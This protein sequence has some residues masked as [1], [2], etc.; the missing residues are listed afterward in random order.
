MT[1]LAEAAQHIAMSEKMPE[2]FSLLKSTQP[3]SRD[4]PGAQT[5]AALERTG[6]Q[7]IIKTDKRGGGYNEGHVIKVC[8]FFRRSNDKMFIAAVVYPGN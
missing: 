7:K 6:K 1:L 8:K 5:S 4:T 3:L 2:L